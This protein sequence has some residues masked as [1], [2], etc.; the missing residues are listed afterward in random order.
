MK[1]IITILLFGLVL[2][3]GTA[4]GQDDTFRTLVS[5]KSLKCQFGPG[6]VG[7]W[8]GAKVAVQQ[9]RFDVAL[10]FD[11]IDAKTGS[12]RMIGNE[13]AADVTVLA[14]PSGVTFVEQTGSGNIVFT[15]VFPAMVPGTDEFYAVTSRHMTLPGG[16]LPSQYHGK[17][18]VWQ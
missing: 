5:A 15:T 13:G 14:S 3:V 6:S 9:E 16:P 12:A 18:R 10:H 11:S 4:A 1:S 8:A 2:G 7:K 17:C